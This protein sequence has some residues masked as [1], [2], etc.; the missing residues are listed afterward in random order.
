M[1]DRMNHPRRIL[2][3]RPSALGDISR[4]IATLATLKNEFPDCDIDWL[5]R[6]GF[7]EAIRHHPA[8]NEAILFDRKRWTRSIALMQQ[9]RKRRYDRVYD[10]QGLSRS[11]LFTCTTFAPRRVGMKQSRELATLGYNVVH[12]VPEHHI[13]DRMIGLLEADGITPVRDMRL[14]T[15]E[16]DQAWR[17]NLLARGGIHNAP[18]AVIAPTAQ[19]ASKRWPIERF[20][21]VAKHL[22]NHNVEHAIIVGSPG[23]EDQAQPL[24]EANINVQLHNL[25]GKTCVGQLMA[26]I[27]QCQVAICHDSAA[28][29]MAIGFGRRAVGLYGLT[30]PER[31]GPYRYPLGTIK[32]PVTETI[33]HKQSHVGPE[34]IARITVDDVLNTLDAVMNAPPPTTIHP[35]N[36]RHHG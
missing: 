12:D 3:V 1:T 13:V 10:L 14:Y 11:A 6:Q 36:S 5:V 35:A 33:R 26:I 34:F 24:T 20:I 17:N 7:E 32:A 15:G 28:L 23:E 21:D 19:W 8:L 22:R 18:Y 25:V 29:H 2:I 4:S 9:L 27:E 16:E 30:Q 31:D